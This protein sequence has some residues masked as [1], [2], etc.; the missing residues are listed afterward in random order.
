MQNFHKV[1]IIGAGPIGLYFASECEKSH[2]DYLIL[3]GS[4]VAGGQIA[5]LYPEKEVVDLPNIKSIIAKDYITSLLNKID[6]K[7]LMFNAN[8]IDIKNG[9]LIEILTEKVH[10]FCEKLV[11]A[12]GLGF[13]KPRPLGIEGED[14]CM[15]IRYSLRNYEFLKDKNVAIFGGGD[16]ALD[17]ARALSK[18]SKGIHLIH[19]RDE[20]RGNPETI[21]DCKDLIVHKPFVP[22]SLNCDGVF[23]KSVTIKKVSDTEEEYLEIPVDYI[24]V[25]F[26]NVA[27]QS[28][29]PFDM[30]G[31]FLKVDSNLQI[32]KNIFAIGDV[33][34]Y[35]NKTRRMAP[36]INEANIVFKQIID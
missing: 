17:W 34:Q 22:Y 28:K 33:A 29:F 23:A 3:E 21:K 24:F 9:D 5:H 31:S 16:S 27:C 18:I 36:G 32:T 8:V 6:Q 19:R 13:S 20:F 30:D 26:G 10:Y 11:I 15:N 35:E 1:I 2:L 25:N 14:G 4:N 12:T 7:R